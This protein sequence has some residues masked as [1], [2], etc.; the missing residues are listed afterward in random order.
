MLVDM[1]HLLFGFKSFGER[2]PRP[3]VA[4][5][6]R[7]K[8]LAP[9]TFFSMALRPPMKENQETIPLNDHWFSAKVRI[10][11]TKVRLDSSKK[12]MGFNQQKI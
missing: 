12:Q 3:I 6:L 11:S 7:E 2:T 5:P 8:S 1:I 10:S 9:A 4:D